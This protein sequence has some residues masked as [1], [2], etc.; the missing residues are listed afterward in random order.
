[1]LE[2][3]FNNIAGVKS[4]SRTGVFLWIL[5]NFLK[6]PILRNICEQLLLK[7]NE[8]VFWLWNIDITLFRIKG[9]EGGSKKV[10]LPFF[11]HVT[12][13][14]VLINP[15]NFL[16]FSFNPFPRWCKISGP[17]IV[18]VPNYWTWAKTKPLKKCFFWSNW[19]YGNFSHRIVRITKVWSNDHI[20]NIIWVTW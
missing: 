5:R 3:L 4:N 18:A 17:Y 8:G 15:K 7:F 2:S 1:M 14:N 16:T 9:K 13:T 19:G 12:P 10:P 20:Y 6:I 11:P